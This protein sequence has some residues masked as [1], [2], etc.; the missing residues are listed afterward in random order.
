MAPPLNILDD[1]SEDL[2]RPAKKPR[3][4]EEKAVDQLL[5]TTT[6]PADVQPELLDIMASAPPGV[7]FDFYGVDDTRFKLGDQVFEAI[8][9]PHDGY[10]SYLK[11][12][13]VCPG[14]RVTFFATPVATVRVTWVHSKGNSYTW[15]GRQFTG[16]LLEDVE[17]GHVWL[18]VGTDYTQDYYPSFTFTY[19]PKPLSSAA[20]IPTPPPLV[21]K[22]RTPPKMPLPPINP[23]TFAQAC[24]AQNASGTSAKRSPLGRRQVSE[25][26]IG[27]APGEKNA[28]S[29]MMDDL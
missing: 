22:K 16:F 14:A 1:D 8:C 21:R 9:D 4:E 27:V 3:T 10:R 26:P 20:I 12:I 23:Q 28:I 13:E 15:E 6:L 2:S 24:A 17:D 19:R 5:A 7:G 25:K 11:S 18:A 29:D